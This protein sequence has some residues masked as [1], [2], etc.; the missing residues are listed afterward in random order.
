MFAEPVDRSFD[1]TGHLDAVGFTK[2]CEY[3]TTGPAE[4]SS[5]PQRVVFHIITQQRTFYEGSEII[6]YNSSDIWMR[7]M[8]DNKRSETSKKTGRRR[9]AIHSLDYGTI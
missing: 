8:T 9:T 5:Y 1:K 6:I 2:G 7:I 4:T 3:I